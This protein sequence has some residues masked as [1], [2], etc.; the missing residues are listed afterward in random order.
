[1]TIYW[2]AD[3]ESIQ[4]ESTDIGLYHTRPQAKDACNSDSNNN[5]DWITETGTYSYA[6]DPASFYSFYLVTR[7][8]IR[9][10]FIRQASSKF[11]TYVSSKTRATVAKVRNMRKH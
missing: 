6:L 7:R 5:L 3:H 11:R 10:A 2:Q 8:S 1:M 9:F 4:S